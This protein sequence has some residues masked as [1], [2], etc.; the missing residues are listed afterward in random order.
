MIL[1]MTGFGHSKTEYNGKVIRVEI[2]SLNARSTEIRCKLPNSYRDREMDL[3]K[4]VI[5]ALQRGKLDLTITVDG[6]SDEENAFINADAFRKYFRELNMLRE[7]LNITEGD[8]LQSVLRIPNVIGQNEDMADEEEW[9]LVEKTV[10]LA[11][12]SIKKFRADEGLVLKADLIERIKAIEQNLK[13]IEPYEI[14][15]L[16]RIKDRLKK[17]MDEFVVKQQVDQNRYEQEILY[18]IEKLDINEEKVRLGQHCIYFMEELDH[19]EDQKGRKLSFIA[20]EIGREINTIGAKAQDSDIQQFV[21][22]MKDE[23]EKLK[24]QLANIL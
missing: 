22:M 16:D 13:S 20:Q 9:K 19:I 18:Y 11:I 10:D 2:K 3:R 17:N 4:R 15:R 8:I 23:L 6:F 24:E 21:V 1:S 5:D 7:E 14:A 12:T